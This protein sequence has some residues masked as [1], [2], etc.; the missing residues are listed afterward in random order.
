MKDSFETGLRML[1]DM[2]RRP[3][4]AAGRDRAAAA[5]DAVRPAGQLRGSGVHRGRRVRSAGLRVSSLRHAA[6]RHAGRRSPPS[7]ATTS[8]AFHRR[9]FVPNN[10]I[11]AVVGDVTADEAFEGVKKVFGDWERR[12]VPADT[13]IAPPD[14]T[15]RVVIVNKPDAVQTEVRVGPPRRQAQPSRLHGAE[16]GHPHPGRRGRQPAAPG[17]ADR[18][19][20]HLR[21]AGRHGH[22]ARK[23]RLRGL[24]QHAIRGDRR[25]AA[26]HGRR[27]LA[28][29][30]RARAAS[31]SWPT[32]RPTSPAASR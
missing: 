8:S 22:P 11:L 15:R 29:A 14:P 5:A 21:R 30:A 4:F 18:A 20:P 31:A 24:D 32:P 6:D 27:V 1:S 16:P 26:P 10:A 9:N 17:A 19:R 3:A 25:S 23:R 13:F 28:P 12:D 2:A 7:R